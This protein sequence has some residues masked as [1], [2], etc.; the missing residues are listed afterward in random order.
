M[1]W[2]KLGNVVLRFT[3]VVSEGDCISIVLKGSI[4][5]SS[6]SQDPEFRPNFEFKNI[7]LELDPRIYL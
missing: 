2:K 3:S 5:D 7:G 4:Y 1:V 6:L